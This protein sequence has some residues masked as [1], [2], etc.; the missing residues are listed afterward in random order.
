MST[1]VKLAIAALIGVVSIGALGST[2][3]NRGSVTSHIASAY[4]KVPNTDVPGAT[5]ST[6]TYKSD[7]SPMATADA[8]AKKWKPAE[9]RD[10]GSGSFLRYS[11]Y[12]VGVVPGAGG[13]RITVDRDRD[14]YNRYFPYIGGF[15]G[16]GSGSGETFRGGGPGVGK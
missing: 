4:A 9:R 8:I 14:G 16:T 1:T 15:W 11:D 6:N 5:T 2:L 10:E 13:S 12:V 7:Q 3:L